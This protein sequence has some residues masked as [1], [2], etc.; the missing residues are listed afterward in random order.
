MSAHDYDPLDPDTLADPFP[1]YA[2]LRRS[3]PVHRSERPTSPFFTLSRHDDV[4]AGLRD[5]ELWSMRYGDSPHYTRPA[6]LFNDPPE[7]TGF[8][9]LFNRG[10]TPRTVGR[11]E[12]DIELLARELIGSMVERGHGD[13]HDC[14]A[15]P[16]PATIIARL[17]GVPPDDL[18][19]F[20]SMCDDLTATYNEADPAV[21]GPPRARIDAYFQHHIDERRAALAA[22]GVVEPGP[23]ALGTVVPDDLLSGLVVAEHDGR[24]LGDDDLHLTLLLLLLGGLETSTALL[25]NM[26]WRLLEDRTRWETVRADPELVDLAVEE[27]LRHDP[28]VLG[29]FRTP[30]RDV[31]LHDVDIPAKAK[32]MLCFASANRDAPNGL[33][34][35]DDFRLDRPI[36]EVRQH[37]SFGFG[38]HYC[39][40]AH[41]ARMEG[42]ISLRVLLEL[43]PELR[44]DGPSERIEPF[45]LWGRR[46]LPVRWD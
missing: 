12:A 18:D 46:R 39:P 34:R 30:T 15:S 7:H 10:F 22:A 33:D 44:L 28:P 23:E 31:E 37:L 14:Y 41:L 1:A 2:E 16:L 9:K 13:F 43:L 29:L 21:S 4:L 27:S 5:W 8:R 3:C 26:V 11:L 36:D 17:L 45:L 24:R 32:V 20:R 38:A 25:T 35:P 40:G 19:L 6:G 42:R